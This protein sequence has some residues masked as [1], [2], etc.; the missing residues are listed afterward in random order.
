MVANHPTNKRPILIRILFCIVTVILFSFA[1]YPV[2]ELDFMTT[3]EKKILVEKRDERLTK[4]LEEARAKA[5]ENDTYPSTVLAGIADKYNL[6]LVDY[7][8]QTNE[9]RTTKDVISMVKR[10][11]AS[12][13]RM[14]IDLSGGV[15]FL[16]E[17]EDIQSEDSSIVVTPMSDAQKTDR[18]R[19][20]V[21][22]RL[23]NAGIYE[24]EI[25]VQ[26]GKFV[27]IRAPIRSKEEKAQLEKLITQAASLRF[28]LVAENSA[29]EVVKYKAALE[30]N[31]PEAYTAPIGYEMMKTVSVNARTNIPETEFYLVRRKAEMTGNNITRASAGRGQYGEIQISLQF[32]N[33]G[34][35]EFGR[36]TT[37]NVGKQLAIVLDGTLYCAPVLKTA[38]VNG[39][40]QITG[41]FTLEEATG[42]ANAL[43]SGNLP[44]KMVVRGVF[45][46]D[47]TLGAANVSAGL[48]ASGLAL[49]AVMLFMFLYY[50]KTGWI[51]NIA[52]LANIVL[53]LGAL[54][55]FHQTLTLPGIA[56]V[57]LTIGM[58][59]DANVLI[60]ERIREEL[61]SGKSVFNAVQSGYDRAFV[62]IFDSNITTLLMGIILVWFSTGAV[63][64]FA[65]VLSIGIITSLFTALTMTHV[66]FDILG[67][68]DRPKTLPSFAFMGIG[69]TRFFN[70]LGTR[71]IVGI[72][73]IILV[74][75]SLAIFISAGSSAYSI[76]FVGG[77]QLSYE[78]K[79]DAR[80]S[81]AVL[82]KILAGNGIEDAKISYKNTPSQQ[83][84]EIIITEEQSQKY[85]EVA[86]AIGD[87]IDK[88]VETGDFLVKS[89]DNSGTLYQ[90]DVKE[91][92]GLVGASFAYTA[93]IAIALACLGILIYVALRFELVFAVAATI[94]LF[95]TMIL[96][97]GAFIAAG[98]QISL[99]V[100]AALLTMYG[101][102]IND[103]IVVFDRIRENHKLYPHTPFGRI[104]ND[105]LNQTLSR[106][107]LTSLTMFL[108]AVILFFFGGVAIHDF[109]FIVLMG[110]IIGTFSSLFVA[111]PIV[112]WWHRRFGIAYDEPS[113]IDYS[114]EVENKS[115]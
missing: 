2:H 4:V 39:A 100:V 48:W 109:A 112:Y 106:T 67:R 8:R 18:A 74:V 22:V 1:M 19:E 35:G 66:I 76:D 34:A 92:G 65:I 97:T 96:S 103:T 86:R 41:N 61:A 28:R 84:V 75:A 23:E 14:G 17:L 45:D 80:V 81:E 53:V 85:D 87:M 60:N 21:R 7:V 3:L 107:I 57:I 78:Y 9:L 63:K 71:R 105:A 111:T 88:P 77:T 58:A 91:I 6:N 110:V 89:S 32:N 70:F 54:A 27:D 38:I 50:P 16:V 115:V 49:F 114:P 40:A 94:G 82:G 55:A 68:Y 98:G 93:F 73:S 44:F 90:V 108:S 83:L 52:L 99:T 79:K 59:V 43:T 10:D 102:A 62:T 20:M 36:V 47:S 101:Y 26:G 5:K 51:A 30:K 95:F 64:G 69:R 37:E 72:V 33:I 24:S 12:A 42:I 25:S 15:E 56:G 11:C 31:T 113:K 13:I 104:I 46:V 29:A